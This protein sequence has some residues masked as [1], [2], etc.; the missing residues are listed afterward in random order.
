MV[1]GGARLDFVEFRGPCASHVHS[2]FKVV[3]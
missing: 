2:L 3:A 1:L